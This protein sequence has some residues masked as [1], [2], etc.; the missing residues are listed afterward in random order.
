MGRTSREKPARLGEKLVQ[1]RNALGLSQ[2]G[3]I[4]TIGLEGK[5]NR[6][7][8]SKY[9]RGVREPS[10]IVLLKYAQAAG[11]CLDYVVNDELNLP[12]KLPSVPMKEKFFCK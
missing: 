4:R 11:V 2:D 9:E 7:D 6:D 10:L 5:L 1:I 12:A 3:I 8:I